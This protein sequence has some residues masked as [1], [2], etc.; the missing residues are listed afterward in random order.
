MTTFHA[1][2]NQ[3]GTNA[4]T[5]TI[6][7]NTMSDNYTP[8]C[9]YQGVGSY[10]LN[11]SYQFPANK[12]LPESEIFNTDLGKIVL[13]RATDSYYTIQT[14][15]TSGDLAN[16]IISNWRLQINRYW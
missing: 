8:S 9:S 1:L 14:Y 15:N 4:P 3:S 6:R 2:L 13:T 10:R 5:M 12:M 11:Y 16:G 7:L